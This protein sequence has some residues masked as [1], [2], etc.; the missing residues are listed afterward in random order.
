MAIEEKKKPLEFSF[1]DEKNN[2]VVY[3]IRYDADDR[4]QPITITVAGVAQSF[5]LNFFEEVV[6]FLKGKGIL[7][8][9]VGIRSFK[10]SNELPSLQPPE[11]QK[12]ETETPIET[13]AAVGPVV[14]LS[15]FDI[16]ENLSDA[17]EGDSGKTAS[18]DISEEI[19]NR[20]V[21]K[22]R[23]RE[24]DPTS[25]EKDAAEIRGIGAEGKN[26]TIKR[27]DP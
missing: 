23:V 24:G 2:N 6:D 5:S 16:S 27:K 19:V 25:A 4:L 12:S 7:K 1:T 17:E 21:I 22:T 10:K 20:K 11:I 26:K 15:S 13:V 14:P 3:E 9:K 8:N 18:Q